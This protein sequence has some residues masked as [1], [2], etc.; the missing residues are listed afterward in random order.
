MIDPDEVTVEE[1]IRL[2]GN[3]KAPKVTHAV[4]GRAYLENWQRGVQIDS[5]I[6]ELE[7]QIKYLQ[8]L[9]KISYNITDIPMKAFA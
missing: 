4:D 6:S 9:K 8:V 3:Y 5:L 1:C 7:T 2:L